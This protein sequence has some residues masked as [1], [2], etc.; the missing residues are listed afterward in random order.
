MDCMPLRPGPFHYLISEQAK[1][2]VA[3]Q[4]LQN[5]VGA[6][7]EFR[8][9][10]IETFPNLRHKMAVTAAVGAGVASSGTSPASSATSCTNANGASSSAHHSHQGAPCTPLSS[11]S[12]SS[13]RM[14]ECWEP[15]KVRRRVAASARENESTTSLPRSRS[16]SHSGGNK[17]HS[18]TVQDSGFSTETSSKDSAS[19]AIACR[20]Q[21]PGSAASGPGRPQSAA[22]NPQLDEAEDELWNLLDVIHRKGVRLREEVECLQGR[23]ESVAPEEL[24]VP[25]DIA[26]AV[27]KV[28]RTRRRRRQ[29]QQ[30]QQQQRRLEHDDDAGEGDAELDSRDDEV[31]DPEDGDDDDEEDLHLGED[32]LARLRREKLQLLD[33]VAELEAETI[34]SRARA[35]ELQAELATLAQL[36]HGLEDRLLLRPGGAKLEQQQQQLLLR[37]LQPI[38]PEPQSPRS[39]A[40]SNTTTGSSATTAVPAAIDIG[41][42]DSAFASVVSSNKAHKNRFRTRT[43]EKSALSGAALLQHHESRSTEDLLLAVT[44]TPT[45]LALD[46]TL[47]REEALL[48]ERRA[49]LGA[50]DSVLVSPVRR[51]PGPIVRSHIDERK[52]V[53]ILRERS[54]LEL[55]RHL[56]TSTVHNQVLQR[57][58]DEV[59]KSSETLSERLGKAHDENEDLRFQ[60]AERSIELEGTRARVRVLERLQQRP[61]TETDADDESD[62]GQHLGTIPPRLLNGSSGSCCLESSGTESLTNLSGAVN[63]NL[64]A[65]TSSTEQRSPQSQQQQQQPKSSPRRK[66]SRIPLPGTPGSSTSSTA[67]TPSSAQKSAAPKPPSTNHRRND[68]RDSLASKSSL[69]SSTSRPTTRQQQRDSSGRESLSLGKSSN[70][71]GRSLT[72]SATCNS[73]SNSLQKRSTSPSAP[74]RPPAPAR[75]SHPQTSSASVASVVQSAGVGQQDSA[76]AAK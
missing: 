41:S 16:N 7:L 64:N 75:R 34:A 24:E 56:I 31:D 11:Q 28:T 43:I 15:G 3:L 71:S 46:G 9:L 65:S 58:L 13:R 49:R 36:R 1:S 14:G 63:G 60:L 32:E 76:A 72:R 53:A 35:Q 55:Q 68:S 38:E 54:P 17:Q 30:Q 50:L 73:N 20:P 2:L 8:D 12:P 40:Q 23:L 10:V 51:I 21:S 66:P 45:T 74:R 44:R 29:Q 5:E 69:Q 47:S 59:E 37:G 61:T 57:R 67:T 25:S 70:V 27:R 6:L 4:E 42:R 33:K 52:I 39:P 18:A 62:V 26:A 22:S 48:K 19:T